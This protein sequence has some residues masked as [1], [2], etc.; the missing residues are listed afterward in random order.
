MQASGASGT[1]IVSAIPC[2]TRERHRI[3]SVVPREC[4]AATHDAMGPHLQNEGTFKMTS[5]GRGLE[6]VHDDRYMRYAVKALPVDRT[7]WSKFIRDG[8]SAKSPFSRLPG[9][10][11]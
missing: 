4:L 11:R 7:A 10:I 9:T 6:S 1:S 3:A 2:G 5:Y 8:F